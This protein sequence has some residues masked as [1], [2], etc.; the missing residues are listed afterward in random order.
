MD[1]LTILAFIIILVAFSMPMIIQSGAQYSHE[2]S[3]REKTLA[4]LQEPIRAETE[5]RMLFPVT[6]FGSVLD[7]RAYWYKQM[8]AVPIN[9]DW[10]PGNVQTSKVVI[11]QVPQDVPVIEASLQ[12]SYDDYL[13]IQMS[14]FI[15]IQAQ[16]RIVGTQ[17]AINEDI[18]TIIGD[19]GLGITSFA[20]TTNNSTEGGN[21]GTFADL[22]NIH[23]RWA[24]M[25]DDYDDL[26]EFG[27]TVPRIMLIT[28]DIA[29]K[30]RSV[31]A[32]SGATVHIGEAKNG[33]AYLNM[34]MR[35]D[36]PPGSQLVVSK[37]FNG[38]V[39]YT[40]GIPSVTAGTLGV[41]LF[42]RDKQILEMLVSP[43]DVRDDPVSKRSGYAMD[44]LWRVVTVWKQQLGVIYEGTF[45][46]T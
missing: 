6:N 15:P 33:L 46:L 4:G 29:K 31:I 43:P 26:M 18:K 25:M 36:A 24:A 41:C 27:S 35:E 37:Y 42:G 12:Y 20:D 44:L 40:E 8:E 39:S 7:M 22:D 21:T 17:L 16:T 9:Y 28:R 11:Q 38:S 3:I 34:L 1:P 30:C 14:N 45:T 23:A 10:K 32:D 5:S 19:T 13:A 2:P